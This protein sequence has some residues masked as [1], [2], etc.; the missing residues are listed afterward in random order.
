[1]KQQTIV[2]AKEEMKTKKYEENLPLVW[3]GSSNDENIF[4]VCSEEYLPTDDENN[5]WV[6]CDMSN[7]WMHIE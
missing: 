6:L 1:M 3:G 7:L 5:P 4:S 2:H